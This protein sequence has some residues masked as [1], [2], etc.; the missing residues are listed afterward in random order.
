[1]RIPRL[2]FLAGTLW[3]GAIEALDAQE[4]DLLEAGESPALVGNIAPGA[5]PL[6]VYDSDNR[7]VGPAAGCAVLLNYRETPTSRAESLVVPLRP[8]PSGWVAGGRSRYVWGAGSAWIY[9]TAA[10]CLGPAFTQQWN[11]GA[12]QAVVDEGNLLW[13]SGRDPLMTTALVSSRRSVDQPCQDVTAFAITAFP[14]TA[15]VDLD[16][17]FTSPFSI[18]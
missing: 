3:C 14:V 9:F 1:M 5:T 15:V 18:R 7:L 16:T 11:A 10:G 17:L 4:L 13:V 8:E 6:S 2:L 12:R